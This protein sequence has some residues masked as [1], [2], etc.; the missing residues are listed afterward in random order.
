ML[1]SACCGRSL[2]RDWHY[3]SF[4]RGELQ[5]GHG[6]GT[7]GTY[8]FSFLFSFCGLFSFFS[9]FNLI[10]LRCA[11]EFCERTDHEGFGSGSAAGCERW[12]RSATWGVCDYYCNIGTFVTIIYGYILLLLS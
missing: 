12:V 6:T 11:G 4:F 2:V 3:I 8:Y 5:P 9:Y 10:V 7:L 1:I